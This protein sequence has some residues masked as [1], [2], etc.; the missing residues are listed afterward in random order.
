MYGLLEELLFLLQALF[1]DGLKIVADVEVGL[2]VMG[3]AS[4]QQLEAVVSCHVGGLLCESLECGYMSSLEFETLEL[5][6]AKHALHDHL[7]CG[8]LHLLA[9]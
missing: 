2:E 4:L 3:V 5:L 6:F 9:R 8:T 7:V 1:L